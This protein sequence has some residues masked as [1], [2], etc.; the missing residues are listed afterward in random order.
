MTPAELD[1]G[2]VL[3][4][5]GDG[6]DTAESESESI[7][8]QP[9][10]VQYDFKH[11]DLRFKIGTVKI[12]DEASALHQLA[13]P[14]GAPPI[15]LSPLEEP[16]QNARSSSGVDSQLSSEYLRTIENEAQK[17]FTYI[18][19]VPQLK[20]P[21]MV[22]F[23]RHV[24]QRRAFL[25]SPPTTAPKKVKAQKV[26]VMAVMAVG[27][28]YEGATL[29]VVNPFVDISLE[30]DASGLIRLL[31]GEV[32]CDTDGAGAQTI[33]DPLALGDHLGDICD[34]ILRVS[35]RIRE[36]W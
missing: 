25:Y 21:D 12:V 9:T 35:D 30:V 1:L 29:C 26:T 18:R 8:S 27:D 4:G 28:W 7:L 23:A 24:T 36:A 2:R 33:A 34:E 15:E 13:C 32:V 14:G 20:R 5:D 17:S 10:V 11:H 3:E 22:S 16:N 19:P 6:E 31:N